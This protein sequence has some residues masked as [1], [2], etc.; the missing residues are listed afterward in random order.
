MKPP[1]GSVAT[2]TLTVIASVASVY[3]A[4]SEPLLGP[5]TVLFVTN[6]CDKLTRGPELTFHI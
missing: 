4:L 5:I 3:P 1:A 2:V 6:S